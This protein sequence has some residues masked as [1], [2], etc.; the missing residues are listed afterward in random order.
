MVYASRVGYISDGLAKCDIPSL[1]L[2]SPPLPTSYGDFQ[3]YCRAKKNKTFITKP[4]SGSQG[5]GIFVFKNPK[6]I[7]PGEH[8][9]VQQYVSKVY[10]YSCVS[11]TVWYTYCSTHSLSLSLSL[12]SHFL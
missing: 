12:S 4:E 6:E 9:V 10:N 1:S 5:K 8:C 7:K 11:H 3:A 2:S